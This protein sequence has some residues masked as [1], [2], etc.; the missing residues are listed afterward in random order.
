MAYG[1]QCVTIDS[2]LLRPTWCVACSTTPEL[3]ALYLMQGLAKAEVCCV[4]N[5]HP[6]CPPALA[7]NASLQYLPHSVVSTL[8]H[9]PLLSSLP[10]PLI[11]LPYFSSSLS[12]FFLLP[13]LPL[14]PLPLLPLPPSPPTLLLNFFLPLPF[15]LK[16][17]SGWM[18]LTVH[19][20]MRYWMNAVTGAG[21]FITVGTAVTWVSCVD[22]VSG[23]LLYP[24]VTIAICNGNNF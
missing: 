14:L 18:T 20:G 22:Q 3:S 21:G 9:C 7:S 16:V 5:Y 11:T 23:R 17:K 2:A 15:T 24:I 1:G 12:S 19:L 4:G 10:P 6:C 13:P 8:S